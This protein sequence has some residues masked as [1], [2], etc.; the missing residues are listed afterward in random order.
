VSAPSDVDDL[1][2]IFR[3]GD[4]GLRVYLTF[5]L[6]TSTHPA[7]PSGPPD[8][9]GP[10]GPGV[11]VGPNVDSSAEQLAVQ[12]LLRKHFGPNCWHGPTDS[13]YR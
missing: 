5:E 6:Q 2:L 7:M 10:I 9:H 11:V 3:P 4:T 1:R 8:E 12:M 13:P